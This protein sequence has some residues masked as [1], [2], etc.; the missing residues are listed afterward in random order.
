[1]KLKIKKSLNYLNFK[2]YRITPIKNYYYKVK[3][4]TLKQI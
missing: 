1:M 4:L 3:T 2:I